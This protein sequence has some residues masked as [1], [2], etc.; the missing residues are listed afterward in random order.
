MRCDWQNILL[1]AIDLIVQIISLQRILELGFP[2]DLCYGYAVAIALYALSCVV[3][4]LTPDRHS[5]FN[6]ILVDGVYVLACQW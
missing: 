4:I 2:V 3:M 6:G 5:A 1:K